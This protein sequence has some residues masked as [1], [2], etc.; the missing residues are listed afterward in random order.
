MSL[1][2]LSLIWIPVGIYVVYRHR[3][4]L[5]TITKHF[6]E[7]KN[8]FYIV[9]FLGIVGSLGAVI[10][11]DAL[12]YHILLP[13]AYVEL[14]SCIWWYTASNGSRP[15]LL[16]CFDALLY[17]CGGTSAIGI[18][19]LWIGIALLMSF[20]QR[21]GTFL[22]YVCCWEVHL[23]YKSLVCMDI[24][25][26][27]FWCL[28]MFCLMNQH[29][30]DPRIVGILAGVTL[31]IKY[32]SLGPL[33]A[34]WLFGISM[35]TENLRYRGISFLWC[36]QSWFYGPFEIFGKACTLCF[37]MEVGQNKF[38]DVGKS[39]EWVGGGRIFDVALQ[40]IGYAKPYSDQFLG[41]IHPLWGLT[42]S[43]C[44]VEKNI[45]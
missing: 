24:I 1:S 17:G 18:F 26:G 45:A 5:E 8:V 4:S 41:R 7:Y 31:S 32:T 20:V 2:K 11:T 15:L 27:K 42:N 44:F 39:M 22:G 36:P 23:F 28:A 29:R 13:K 30:Y 21:G 33:L 25:D 6:D 10:D 14:W 35:K 12:Y 43:S 34:I 40:C 16:P 19:R 38:P 37:P 3:Y 9:I